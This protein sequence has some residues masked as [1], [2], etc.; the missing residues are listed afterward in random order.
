MKPNNRSTSPAIVEACSGNKGK[1]ENI[2]SINPSREFDLR[3]DVAAARWLPLFRSPAAPTQHEA[4]QGEHGEHPAEAHDVQDRGAVFAG[5]RIVMK[6]V[7][8]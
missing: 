2:S 7:E 1:F 8:Q 5:R 3:H 6:T 4:H